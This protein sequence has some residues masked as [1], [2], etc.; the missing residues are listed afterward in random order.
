MVRYPQSSCVCL[1]TFARH[2]TFGVFRSQDDSVTTHCASCSTS[3]FFCSFMIILHYS[4]MTCTENWCNRWDS[5][6]ANIY[7]CCAVDWHKLQIWRCIQ[8]YINRGS[9]CTVVSMLNVNAPMRNLD[10]FDWCQL[11]SA[12]CCCR[13]NSSVC[14]NST[15][16]CMVTSW[17]QNPELHDVIVPN[18]FRTC[19]IAFVL[20]LPI[21][22]D[23]HN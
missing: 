10:Q 2:M 8:E 23:S 1:L 16:A 7:G 9:R 6:H 22:H 17:Q 21:V 14:L 12:G 20:S 15:W 13:D 18:C 3:L 19:C 11:R 4:S 5:M